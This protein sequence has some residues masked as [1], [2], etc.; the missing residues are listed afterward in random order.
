MYVVFF[1]EIGQ[2]AGKVGGKAAN[3]GKMVDMG[4]PV[5]PGFVVTTDAYDSF[6]RENGLEPKIAAALAGLSE[7]DTK[8][9]RRISSEIQNL[10]LN[11]KIPD[12]V[13]REI[14]EAYQELS[15]G[16]EIKRMG[17]VALD[18]VKVGREAWVAVRSS[19]TAEDMAN[20]SFAGQMRTILNVR[21]PSLLLSVKKCW[22]SLYTGRAM[23]YRMHHG[24]GTVSM[25]VAVQKML[26]ADR[27]GVMFT[28]DPTNNDH[29][30][31]LIEGSFGLGES[32]VSGQVTPDLYTYDK[33]AR[34][35]EEVKIGKKLWMEKVDKVSGETV[36]MR[37]PDDKINA[38]VLTDTQIT[39]LAEL[40]KK[41]EEYFRKPQDVE[42]SEE[43]G[44]LFILQTRPITTLD[45]TQQG[46]DIRVEG[47]VITS[48]SR[49]CPGVARGRVKIVSSIDDLEKVVQGDILV[50]RMT[51][52]D[53]VPY[54]KRAGAIVTEEGG[55]TSHAAIV[56][57]ELSIP[58]IV[59]TGDAMSKLADGAEVIVDATNGKVYSP[60]SA[61]AAFVMQP[62][63][64]TAMTM[65]SPETMMMDQTAYNVPAMSSI[66]ATRIKVNVGFA[67][68]ATRLSVGTD[69]V[70]LIRAEHML[71]ESGKHPVFL[72][73]ENPEELTG[74]I[75]RNLETI[76]RA[77]HPRPVWYRTLDARTDEFRRLQGG[78]SEPMEANPMLGWHGIRRSVEQPDVFRCE[79][80]AIRRL[81]ERG[82]NNIGIMLPFIC[83]VEELRKAKSMV[84]FP[85][86][87]GIMVETPAA[88]MQMD[89]FCR[90]GIAFASFGTNDL[91][92]L[93][94]GVDRN[95]NH[96]AY[97]YD[98]SNPGVLALMREATRACKK[99]GVEVSVCGEAASNPEMA[100]RFV[101]MGVDSLSVEGDA[102]E[103]VRS[104]VA[105]VE[106]KLLLDKARGF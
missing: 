36:R 89:A 65:P 88:A 20:A 53:M 28:V 34:R 63:A 7:E 8:S 57:R 43:R 9:I 52:P 31:M 90:E 18:L 59:G 86:P 92:Q 74:L 29:A 47:E 72:A 41:L 13:E 96:L 106:R 3:L 94:L 16:R 35:V 80:E 87:V 61:P 19:A 68:T 62:Q 91:T 2:A 84:M 103:T 69:G 54:M 12:D 24:I 32:V 99:A 6:I 102:V 48:G 49:A 44:R 64:L 38:R 70:G 1:D 45:T 14:K 4:M 22:A 25:G 23:F 82:L 100:A 56:S 10:I 79:L 50:T 55:A 27:S 26:D 37:I 78:E 95:S 75:E 81:R 104:T 40:G 33:E 30:H 97:V 98:E 21:G 101:E 105:R 93:A 66:T 58:C 77:F 51:N 11:S 76:A 17:G 67:E 85:V 73:K 83:R 15:V 60:S 46:S 42:W 39:K 71:T 5:P